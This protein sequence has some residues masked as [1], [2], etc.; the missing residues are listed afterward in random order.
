[1]VNLDEKKIADIERGGILNILCLSLAAVGLV[2]FAVCYPVARVNDLSALLLLSYIL[3][4]V[5]VGLGAAGGAL[6][7]FKYGGAADKLIRQY[8]LDICL[9]NPK[10]LHPERDSLTFCIE[11]EDKVF[12]IRANGYNEKLKFDFS[13]FKRL[14]PMRKTDIFNEICNRLIV[15][16]CRLYD[17]GA[18]Y[19]EVNYNVKY[20]RRKS[21]VIPIITDGTPDKKSYKIYLKNKK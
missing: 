9:E 18:K 5:L 7:S 3:S 10:A 12:S 15:S 14:S 4:P 20:G 13:A 11:L 1:M 19:R 2:F 8:V 21:K 17:R 16:F 6:C